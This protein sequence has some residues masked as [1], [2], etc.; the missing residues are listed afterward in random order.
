[1][2]LYPAAP[3][4]K[5]VGGLRSEARKLWIYR[6]APEPGV[7]VN[8]DPLGEGL[9]RVFPDGFRPLFAPAAA[10]P[11]PLL[12][13]DVPPVVPFIDDPVVALLVAGPTAA[14]LPPVE[15]PLCASA[16][17]LVSASAAANPIL[18]NLMASF[19][20]LATK[21]K[22]LHRDKFHRRIRSAAAQYL[23]LDAKRK[24]YALKEVP[25]NHRLSGY[26]WGWRC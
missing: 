23:S 12:R 15:P 7:G 1:L 13:L 24:S 2:F 18:V 25:E 19:L 5:R 26:R 22:L 6:P 3:L 21:D 20:I 8:V 11:A 10:L 4:P 17:V 16:E 9:I 14:E